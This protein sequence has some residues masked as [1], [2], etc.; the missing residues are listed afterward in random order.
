MGRRVWNGRSRQIG[1][2]PG[3]PARGHFLADVAVIVSL[4]LDGKQR[5]VVLQALR[6]TTGGKL[7]AGAS[8]LICFENLLNRSYR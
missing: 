8:F 4:L 7:E 5:V 3:S 2:F 1:S 6:V